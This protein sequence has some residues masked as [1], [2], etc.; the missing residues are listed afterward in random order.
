M[1]PRQDIVIVGGGLAGATCALALARSSDASVALI[2]RGDRLGGNHTWCLHAD[3]VPDHLAAVIAPAIA[4]RW[5]GYSVVFPEHRREVA[6]PYACVTSGSLDAAT[7]AA[8]ATRPGFQL[9]VGRTASEVLANRVVLDDGT[10]IEGGLVVDARGPERYRRDTT[11]HAYQKFLGLELELERPHGLDRPILM[12]ATVPQLDGFRFV[13][14]LPLAPSRLLVEDTYYSDSPELDDTRL[15]AE[16]LA[17]ATGLGPS[18]V[19]IVRSERGVLPLPLRHDPEPLRDDG[20]IV[21]GYQG[22]WFHPTTGY[23]FPLALRVAA[24]VARAHEPG[25]RDAWAELVDDHRRQAAFAVRLNRMMFA[26]FRPERRHH[27]LARF[28]RMPEA[29]IR[30]FY[31]MRTTRMD[32][33]RVLFGRPP[34]GMSWRAALTGGAVT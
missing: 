10:V 12:D 9:I 27:L 16:V 17:Y 21:A 22:G 31:A 5:D 19:R 34:R 4:H 18:V 13:Y 23:S 30:R 24:L 28:Y 11:P 25:F 1:M 20:P 3:D 29:T 14:V 7:R 26:W 6:S 33:A 32:R 8:V 2:E 15:T